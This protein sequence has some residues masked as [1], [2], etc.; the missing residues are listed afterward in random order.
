[1]CS[2]AGRLRAIR[3]APR[4]D[5]ATVPF[6]F[7]IGGLR[8]RPIRPRPGC[9]PRAAGERPATPAEQRQAAEALHFAAESRSRPTLVSES[10]AGPA[11]RLAVAPVTGMALSRDH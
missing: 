9:W 5:V 10:S 1:M 3:N 11:E 2:D 6:Q 8:Q 7:R 4:Y